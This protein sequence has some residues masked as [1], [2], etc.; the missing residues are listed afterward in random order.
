MIGWPILMRAEKSDR[1]GHLG[2][3][4]RKSFD[5]QMAA[6]LF[7]EFLSFT[8]SAPWCHEFLMMV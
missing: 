7:F 2:L 3:T 6:Q 1:V 4:E 8:T 5:E